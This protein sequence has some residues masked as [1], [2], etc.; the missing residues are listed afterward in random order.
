MWWT[1]TAIINA[2]VAA[3]VAAG[4]VFALMIYYMFND[5]DAPEE[6][7]DNVYYLGL[8]FTL[9]SLMS[10]LVELFGH[11]TGAV[12]NAEKIQVL[13]ENFG[14][15]LSST[16]VGIAGRVA[17]LNWQRATSSDSAVFSEDMIIPTPPPQSA[18]VKDLE[19]F[20]R[21]LLGR[22][23]RDLTQGANALARFNRI[24][25]SHAT[26]SK[27]FL[28]NH[29]EMLK[30]ESAEFKDT[31]QRNADTFV[32]DLRSQ[33]EGTLQTVGSSLDTVAQQAETLLER[34]QSAHNDYL[35]EVRKTTRSFHDDIQTESSK[36]LEALQKNSDDAAKQSRS[37]AETLSGVNERIDWAFNHFESSI[38]QASDTST[39]LSDNINQAA[40]ST[41]LMEIEIGKLRTSLA[42]LH[43]STEAM[44]GMLDAIGELDARI[45]TDH[46]TEQTAAAVW[47]IGE[48]LRTTTAEAAAATEHAARAAEMINTLTVTIQSIES[49][50]RRTAEALQALTTEA[51][52]RLES[53]R[54]HQRPRFGFW[55]RS[56]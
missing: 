16:V 11:D 47:Q 12:R 54:Q 32:Q 9:I 13:L 5:V 29:S 51:E 26:E 25:Q 14:I 42:P 17:L 4:V 33:A 40:N 41:A 45:R 50:T 35:T 18:N 28:H 44:T 36:Y 3:M 22:I 8:L 20:N 55:N 10:T 31:L 24:V 34:L 30:R 39:T 23:A 49:E 48:T 37:L 52:A 56:R 15:A 21:N 53:L 27:D 7:G 6:E 38:R 46:D 2:W 1:K 19:G 43:A